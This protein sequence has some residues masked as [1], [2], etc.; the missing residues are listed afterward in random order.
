MERGTETILV[1]EDEVPVRNLVARVL[2]RAGY[3]V[4]QAG[5][6]REVEAALKAGGPSPGPVLMMW[7]CREA[8]TAATWQRCSGERYPGLKVIYM[9]G[10]TRD[11]VVH[12]GRLVE[13]ID[14]LEKPFTPEALLQKVR[15]VLDACPSRSERGTPSTPSVWRRA[16]SVGSSSD[17]HEP[18]M[19]EVPEDIG[20]LR[21]ASSSSSA[22]ECAS[23]C[24]LGFQGKE[25][26]LSRPHYR[27]YPCSR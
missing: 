23:A 4:L 12:N 16:L 15:L 13:G 6:I 1:V 5:S 24:K 27:E 25:W 8:G 26:K 18:F 9:S 22:V 10:Y 19:C 7:Y 21:L 14:F 2:S 3:Q 11:S 17:P 20:G